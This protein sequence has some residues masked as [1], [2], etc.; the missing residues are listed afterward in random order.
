MALASRIDSAEVA[1]RIKL[2]KENLNSVIR[3]KDE[4]IDF[5]IMALIAGESVLVEDVPGVGKTTLAKAIAA[6]L[7]LQFQRVQC[8][9]DLLPADIFGVSIFN[10]KESTFQFR[11]GPVFCNILLVDEINRASP[12]TQSALLEAMAEKQVTVE[13][14][15]YGLPQ[16]FQ[17]IATQN[18]LGFRGTFPLPESQL[19]RFSMQLE[20]DY[21]DLETEL[22]VLYQES[23]TSPLEDLQPVLTIGEV[24]EFQ[25]SLGEVAFDESLAKYLLQIVR[26][27]RTDP[28]IELSCSPRGAIGFFKTAK[29]AALI[30]GRKMVLPDDIQ[31]VA[32]HVLRH[33]LM[34]TAQHQRISVDDLIQEL[35]QAVAV[36]V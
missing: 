9:P 36:P 34:P 33:R 26:Q 22:Q 11:K 28:R 24:I 35:V 21:P 2:L 10:P 15:T 8:T 1:S 31:K 27:T 3:G 13:G 5:I 18:P 17:V 32:P 19:D 14:V 12:R 6:S 20:M 16:P 30:D 25:D 4:V 29:A 7:E 23:E